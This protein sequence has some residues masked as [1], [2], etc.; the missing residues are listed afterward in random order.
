MNAEFKNGLSEALTG[1]IYI[2]ETDAPIEPFEGG[3]AAAATAENLLPRIGASGDSQV[4]E[5]GF[6]EIFARLT[7]VYEGAD[8][9]HI[10]RAARF[11]ALKGLLEQNLSDLK[12]FKV[13]RIN[14]DIY[15]VGLDG[16]G[17]LTGV[18]TKSVET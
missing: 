3:P 17:N 13:G 12:V 7:R 9:E 10:A 6:E 2:S 16:E 8:E 4:E 11:T 5:R 14:V 15:I 1:L 18:K